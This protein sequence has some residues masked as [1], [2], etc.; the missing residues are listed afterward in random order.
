VGLGG[1]GIL[2]STPQST[3][4]RS[5]FGASQLN[6]TLQV[7][8]GPRYL[9]TPHAAVSLEYRPHHISDANTT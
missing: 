6:F 9:L 3:D 8:P 2:L 5:Q 7:A 4:R 1:A